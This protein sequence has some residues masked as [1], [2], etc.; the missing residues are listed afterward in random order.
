M[1]Q[2]DDGVAKEVAVGITSTVVAV[3]SIAAVPA[4]II[5]ALVSLGFHHVGKR[6][7]RAAEKL[8]DRL[9]DGDADLEADLKRRLEAE[10]EE[11]L[12]AFHRLLVASLD[13][14][15]PA[16]T[17]P[18]AYVGR[19]YLKN[20]V[21]KWLARAAVEVLRRV[22]EDELAA[23]R[24]LMVE[25][26]R[27]AVDSGENNAITIASHKP[28][29][30]WNANA[31]RLLDHGS[32]EFRRDIVVEESI[33][34]AGERARIKGRLVCVHVEEPTEQQVVVE[35]LAELPIAADRVQRHQYLRLEQ[36]LGW[37][38]RPPPF[39][40]T[41]RRTSSRAR[42]ESRLPWP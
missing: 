9:V 39:G 22:D 6:S 17:V 20:Q 2:A 35:L 12:T 3:A 15:T 14:V 18:M 27:V 23:L 31:P 36:A 13:A 4:A 5:P 21:P 25:V 30:E 26:E 19:L 10:D 34:V 38:R 24:R 37:N 11:I 33:S 42:A 40:C 41:S 7:L 29:R 8:F 28:T 1:K 32:E 16:A